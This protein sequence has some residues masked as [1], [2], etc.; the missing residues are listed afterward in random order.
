LTAAKAVVE[1]SGQT[2]F[3]FMRQTHCE[4]ADRKLEAAG[5]IFQSIKPTRFPIATELSSAI[6]A[7]AT[8]PCINEH[9][10][11]N[12]LEIVVYAHCGSLKNIAFG[13][14]TPE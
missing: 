4:A 6:Q 11:S 1:K 2:N 14:V 10:N 5:G 9:R 12:P 13:Q 3:G 8:V 7:P